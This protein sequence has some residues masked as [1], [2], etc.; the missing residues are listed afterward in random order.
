MPKPSYRRKPVSRDIAFQYVVGALTF[1]DFGS[2][3][4]A[5]LRASRF[6]LTLNSYGNKTTAIP[7]RRLRCRTSFV[8]TVIPRL[9]SP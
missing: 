1:L 6:P 9:L 8:L 3:R 4:Y 2:C 5:E 7:V